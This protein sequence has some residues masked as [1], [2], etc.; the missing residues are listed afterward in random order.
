MGTMIK[1]GSLPALEYAYVHQQVVGLVR[2]PAGSSKSKFDSKR[3]WEQ[4]VLPEHAA[5]AASHWIV[6]G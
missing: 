3:H 1:T 2:C 6:F 4:S 5:R